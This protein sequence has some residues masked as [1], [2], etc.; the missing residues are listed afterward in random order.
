[1]EKE[2]RLF[3]KQILVFSLIVAF[4]EFLLYYF[5]DSQWFSSSWPFVLAFFLAF[6][7]LMHRQLVKSAIGNAKKFITSFLL[8]T[9][10]KILLYLAIIV[11]YVL[12]N[13]DD[14]LGFI[15]VFFVNYLFYTI[16]E[17]NAVLKILR[18]LS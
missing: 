11:I 2:Y 1:M 3:T 18:S 13:R 12:I 16:F 4:L 7:I 10:I 5:L 17:L 8:M 15:V 9:T 6:T 14:A